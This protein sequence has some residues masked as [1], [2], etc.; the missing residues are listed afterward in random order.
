MS[1]VYSGSFGVQKG[2]AMKSGGGD[3]EKPFINI[4]NLNTRGGHI[5]SSI[6]TL[7]ARPGRLMLISVNW[8]LIPI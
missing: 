3:D 2:P 4:A 8:L 1:D 7:A 6:N 5:T